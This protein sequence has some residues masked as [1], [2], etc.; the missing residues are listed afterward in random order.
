MFNYLSKYSPK[1]TELGDNMGELTKKNAPFV[2][3]MA[4]AEVLEAIKKITCALMLECYNHS[5]PLTLQAYASLKGLGAVLL[6]EDHPIYFPSKSFQPHQKAQV[7]I[8][9]ESLAAPRTLGEFFYFLFGKR[10]QLE[11]DQRPL[12]NVLANNKTQE[13]PK[14]QHLLIM[15]LSYDFSVKCKT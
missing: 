13:R 1:L 9:L 4:H 12:E 3:D 6:Q 7:A 11:M 10:F 8:E 14:L 5:K 15:T 2:W